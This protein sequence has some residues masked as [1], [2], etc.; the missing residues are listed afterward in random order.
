MASSSRS[1]LKL[2]FNWLSWFKILNIRDSCCKMISDLWSSSCWC[3]KRWRIFWIMFC[4]LRSGTSSANNATISSF[5]RAAAPVLPAVC[6]LAQLIGRL[7]QGCSLHSNQDVRL[8]D[9]PKLAPKKQYKKLLHLM[10]AKWIKTLT[11]ATF[12]PK[13]A[14]KE[15]VLNTMAVVVAAIL[16]AKPKIIYNP[17]DKL[18]LLNTAP[19]LTKTA[20]PAIAKLKLLVANHWI[21]SCG[22][23]QVWR[24]RYLLLNQ[25]T[26]VNS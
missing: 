25:A 6:R 24:L 11:A 3:D 8:L 21:N 7:A 17:P 18:V 1:W 10:V 4:A 23:A 19:E 13:L 2:C 9:S 16:V 15:V 26:P 12:R 14:L 20:T 5:A 22:V